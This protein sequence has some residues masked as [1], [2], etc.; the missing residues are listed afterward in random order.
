M[1][2]IVKYKFSIGFEPLTT[3]QVSSLL[4]SKALLI[5]SLSK[6]LT[7]IYKQL[8]AIQGQKFTR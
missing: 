6:I 8:L 7:Q 3:T 5:N 4:Y 2:Y 1:K